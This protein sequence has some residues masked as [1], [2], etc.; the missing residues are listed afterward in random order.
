[1]AQNNRGDNQNSGRGF[2]SM[3]DDKQ[4]EIAAEGGRASHASG[5]GHE[6]DSQEAS[7]AGRKGGE[8]RGGQGERSVG[9]GSRSDDRGLQAGGRGR[10]EQGQFTGDRSGSDRGGNDRGSGERSDRNR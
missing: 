2:A 10:D 3:D 7:E 8:A 1:M 5:R 9:S 4:R 6:F